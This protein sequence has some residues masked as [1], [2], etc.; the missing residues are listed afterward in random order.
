MKTLLINDN[1]MFYKGVGN[2]EDAA[3][4]AGEKIKLPHTWN[5][6]DGQ[7]GGSDYFRGACLYVKKLNVEKKADKVY[8]IE[9]RAVNSIADVFVNGSKVVHHEGG[10]S[11][12]RANITDLLVSGENTVAVVADNS[13]SDRI[14]PQMADFTFFGGIYRNVYL[15]ETEKSRFDLDYGYSRTQRRR[16]SRSYRSGVCYQPRKR[17]TGGS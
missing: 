8:Y 10:F 11:T 15:I 5:N 9:F 2:I 1:W 7:D 13:P 4:S 6:M 12:F 17:A 3:K 14:Y 16:K